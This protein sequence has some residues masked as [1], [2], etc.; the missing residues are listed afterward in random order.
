M[1]LLVAPPWAYIVFLIFLL[2]LSVLCSKGHA[3]KGGDG[4]A[5]GVQQVPANQG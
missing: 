1:E 3:A 5:G 4:P 2:C